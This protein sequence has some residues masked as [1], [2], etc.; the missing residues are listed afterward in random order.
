MKIPEIYINLLLYIRKNKAKNI[1]A[2]RNTIFQWN[3]ARQKKSL[4]T[5][6]LYYTLCKRPSLFMLVTSQEFPE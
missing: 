6:V 5:P 1:F 3:L 2:A 4:A